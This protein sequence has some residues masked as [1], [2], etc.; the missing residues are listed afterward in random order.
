LV[1]AVDEAH[2]YRNVRKG[3][4]AVFA[5]RERSDMM[6][7]MTATPAVGGPEVCFYSQFLFCDRFSFVLFQDLWNLGRC[8]GLQGFGSDYDDEARQMITGLRAA[9]SKDRKRL[10]NHER[11]KRIIQAAVSGDSTLQVHSHY[12]E[13]MTKWAKVIRQRFAGLTIRRSLQSVDNAGERISGLGPIY[14]HP[15]LIN[16]Y[17]QEMENLEALANELVADGTHRSAKAAGSVSI[18]FFLLQ[19]D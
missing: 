6:V 16:L 11:K 14:E 5:L 7:A 18:F 8:M 17:A 10:K 12:H 3:F 9:Q 2:N 13:E 1:T 19:H 15:L 4:W